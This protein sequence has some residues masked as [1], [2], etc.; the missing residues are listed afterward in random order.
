MAWTDIA[1]REHSRAGLRYPSDMTDREWA[2]AAPFVPPAKTGGRR[3]TTDMREVVNALL[4]LASAGCAW[5]M[6]P[7][8]RFPTILRIAGT[9]ARSAQMLPAALD[10]QALFL[11]L[12]RCRIVRCDQHGAGDEPARNRGTRSLAYCRSDRQP[13]VQNHRKRR[14]FGL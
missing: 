7:P 1:R 12:A 8:L 4:Y 2:L 9:L 3:R 5:R 6:L 10:D 11:C 14:C 13:V